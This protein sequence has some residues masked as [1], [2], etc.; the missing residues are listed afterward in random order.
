M[1]CSL[2][3]VKTGAN[4]PASISLGKRPLRASRWR[5]PR[6]GIFAASTPGSAFIDARYALAAMLK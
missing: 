3:L 6:S 1:T 4:F 5:M 2:M